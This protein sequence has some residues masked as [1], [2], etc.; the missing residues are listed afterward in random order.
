MA[1]YTVQIELYFD[2]LVD[3]MAFRDL[4]QPSLSKV[5]NLVQQTSKASVHKCYHDEVPPKP[6]ESP[7]WS[8]EKA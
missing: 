4:I 7:L 3:A 2:S 1:V 6:C 5:R 8:W